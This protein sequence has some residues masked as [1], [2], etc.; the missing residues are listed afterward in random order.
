MPVSRLN[1]GLKQ[2]PY[3]LVLATSIAPARPA[4]TTSVSAAWRSA[5]ISRW[6]LARM[7]MSLV[8]DAGDVRRGPAGI[9]LQ[10]DRR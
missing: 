9:E 3:V 4:S 10:T 6:Q 5:T 2:P 1:R 7:P 8:L